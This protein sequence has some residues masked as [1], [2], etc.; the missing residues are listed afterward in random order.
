MTQ[1]YTQILFSVWFQTDDKRDHLK[2]STIILFTKLKL[3]QIFTL[4]K[5]Q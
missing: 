3:S 4:Y 2:P 5:L 1:I